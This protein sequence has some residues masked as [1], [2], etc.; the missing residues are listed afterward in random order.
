MDIVLEDKT[1]DFI[2]L[3]TVSDYLCLCYAYKL[4]CPSNKNFGGWSGV[5]YMGG[6]SFIAVS[7]RGDWM[8]YRI[9]E[10]YGAIEYEIIEFSDL[11]DENSN[12]LKEMDDPILGLYYADAEEVIYDATQDKFIVVF[13]QFKG[14]IAEYDNSMNP[15]R[16]FIP[17]RY[18]SELPKN[19]KI[20]AMAI[21]DDSSFLAIAESIDPVWGTHGYLVEKEGGYSFFWY[22]ATH[23]FWVSSLTT[24][25]N[26]DFLV[27]ERRF[28]FDLNEYFAKLVYLERS[29]VFP[30][31][32]ASGYEV[33]NIAYNAQSSIG[34][35]HK[36]ENF[37]GVAV[38]PISPGSCFIHILSDNNFDSNENT[39]HLKLY[40]NYGQFIQNRLDL[41]HASHDWDNS[42]I[43]SECMGREGVS[44]IEGF[45]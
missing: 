1:D 28:D 20:E 27:L 23:D 44:Q 26:N 31:S 10:H 35:N 3:T 42:V 8:K 14:R 11:Q 17:P 39:I 43:T 38:E 9:H 34:G 15:V 25:P 24:L 41:V 22:Q 32:I 16:D 7:D 36:V 29:M 30:D 2:S 5:D 37:E 13:E 6:N 33:L 4:T 19:E 45:F 12:P 40:F 18:I 21:F